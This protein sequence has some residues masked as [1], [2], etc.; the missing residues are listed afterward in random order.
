MNYKL[1]DYAQQAA[2][3]RQREA[4]G[5]HPRLKRA[6]F[7]LLGR[8]FQDKPGEFLKERNSYNGRHIMPEINYGKLSQIINYF[9]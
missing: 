2:S 4:T 9:F 3:E 7:E 6:L 1:W 8:L 5:E